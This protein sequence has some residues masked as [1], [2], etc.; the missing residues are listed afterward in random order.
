MTGAPVPEGADA[1]VPVEKARFEGGS[2]LLPASAPEAHVVERGDHVRSG[3][4]VLSRGRVVGA[5]DVGAL[6]TAGRASVAV[7][8]RPRVAVLGTGSELVDV[9]RRP[10][11]GQIRNSNGFSLLAQAVVHG[12]E[13]VALGTV[14]DDLGALR[15]AVRRGLAADVLV[16]SGGVSR[17]E[18]DLVPGALEAEGVRCAFHRW[19]VQPG[20][21]LWFGARGG[22]P[23]FG[24]P[25]NPAASFVG[26]EIL[27]VP[28]LRALLGR[29][30]APR[31]ALRARWEGPWSGPADRRRFRPAR[32]VCETGGALRAE[33]V[34]WKGSG[35]PFGVARG[36]VLVVL[37]EGRT[38]PGPDRA[39]VDAVPLVP[40]ALEP[41]AVG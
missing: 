7:V 16:L 5:G 23:V 40:A 4:R 20:G 19:R 30:F 25:G 6:A 31:G 38:A 14:G 9:A 24:L 41:G 28:V 27:V 15:A 10:G 11:P 2:V 37:P 8:A 34:P 35:D 22:R 26:F 17:G 13:P 1:V 18:L 36:D 21:P 32:L 12:A 33:P 39:V 3:E 29:P